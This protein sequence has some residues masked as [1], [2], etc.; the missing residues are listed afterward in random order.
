MKNILIIIGLFFLGCKNST[1]EKV[2]YVFP[3]N[4]IGVAVIIFDQSNGK[5]IEYDGKKRVYRIPSNGILKTKFKQSKITYDYTFVYL[6]SLGQ[7]NNLNYFAPFDLE[8]NIDSNRV[9]CYNLEKIIGGGM[10]SRKQ[11]RF[12][13]LIVTTIAKKDSISRRKSPVQWQILSEL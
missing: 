12:E 9:F 5:E 13:S 8:P 6:D 11:I 3:S 10:K 4:F 2:E 7:K 1:Y